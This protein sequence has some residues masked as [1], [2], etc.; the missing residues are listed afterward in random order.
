MVIKQWIFYENVWAV[1]LSY[2]FRKLI[3]KWRMIDKFYQELLKISFYFWI[4]NTVLIVQKDV[5]A[6][7][8]HLFSI[9]VF[10]PIFT[11][12]SLLLSRKREDD[13]PHKLR[14]KFKN[15]SKGIAKRYLNK[16]GCQWSRKDFA[17]AAS[18]ILYS[19]PSAVSNSN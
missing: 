5:Y 12:S 4:I 3:R 16:R 13:P 10:R 9:P 8:R 11:S 18:W 19:V 2:Q 6:L 14:R 17:F 15:Q 1:P 7:D